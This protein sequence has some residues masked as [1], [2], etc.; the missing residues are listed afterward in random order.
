LCFS[1]NYLIPY[2]DVPPIATFVSSR[3]SKP[4]QFSI[5]YYSVIVSSKKTP[6]PAFNKT[7]FRSTSCEIIWC[8][9]YRNVV[10]LSKT[11]NDIKNESYY[12]ESFLYLIDSKAA[13]EI[14]LSDI[15]SPIHDCKFNEYFPSDSSCKNSNIPPAKRKNYG[16]LIILHGNMP[17]SFTNLIFFFFNDFYIYKRC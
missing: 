4:A 8:N 17:C 2:Q 14:I 6:S 12:G 15:S 3:G 5:Y 9:N 16:E 13:Q 11:E 1:F 10:C 7:F